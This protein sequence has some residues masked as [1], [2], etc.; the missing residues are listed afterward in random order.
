MLPPSTVKKL[1]QNQKIKVIMKQGL[2]SKGAGEWQE[3]LNSEC[4]PASLTSVL[5]GEH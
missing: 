2:M 1:E 4:F 5:K 3:S